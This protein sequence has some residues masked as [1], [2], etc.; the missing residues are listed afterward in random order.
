M[1]PAGSSCSVFKQ[2]RQELGD[3][4][5]SVYF[6]LFIN[7][8]KLA[9]P[10]VTHT[11]RDHDACRELSTLQKQAFWIDV[12]LESSRPHTVVLAVYWRTDVE[13]LLI[14]EE[15]LLYIGGGHSAQQLR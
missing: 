12:M 9:F 1:N 2:L 4:V 11:S 5:V 8:R 13:Q 14:C 15:S 7:E 3:V 6:S 10:S